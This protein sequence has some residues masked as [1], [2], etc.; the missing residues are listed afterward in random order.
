[1]NQVRHGVVASLGE[2]ILPRTER[3][4]YVGRR[5]YKRRRINPTAGRKHELSRN[6]PSTVSVDRKNSLSAGAKLLL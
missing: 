6:R 5:R 3:R 4:L 1:M 2:I